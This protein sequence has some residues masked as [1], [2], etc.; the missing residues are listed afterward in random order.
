[1]KRRVCAGSAVLL[2]LI[3]SLCPGMGA[4]AAEEPVS[5][6]QEAADTGKTAQP[7]AYR[8]YIQGCPDMYGSG[9]VT[10]TAEDAA[11]TDGVKRESGYAGYAD[12]AGKPLSALLTAPEA[13]ATWRVSVPADGRYRLTVAYYPMEGTGKSAERTLLLDGQVP[14]A[15]AESLCFERT[16]GDDGEKSVDKNGNES[17]PSQIETPRWSV[18]TLT[19]A[20]GF[21]GEALCLY[22]TAG[23][24]TVSLAGLREPVAF[25]QLT[26]SPAAPVPTYAEVRAAA[27]YPDAAG[28]EAVAVIPAETAGAR[29]DPTLY[30]TWDRSSPLT[31]PMDYHA[32]RLNTIGGTQ[33][34]LA[35]QW[36]EWTFTVPQDGCYRIALRAR[37][38]QTAG[39]GASR[40]L[41][42][43]GE[44]PFAEAAQITVPYSSR[45][46]SV[47]LGDKQGD[48]LFPLSAGTH[49]LRL[50]VT[51]GEL[52]ELAQQTDALLARL[53]RVYREIL[54]ITGTSPDTYRDYYLDKEIPDTLKEMAALSGELT[55]LS[56]ALTEKTGGRSAQNSLLDRLARETAQMSEKPARVAQMLS[57]FK[58]DL[59]SLGSWSLGIR[60]QPLELDTIAVLPD[61]A[62]APAGDAGFFAGL[63]HEL[64]LFAAAFTADYTGDGG[65][66]DENAVE[67]WVTGGREQ[68]QIQRQMTAREYSAKGQGAVNIRL[69]ASSA[70]LPSVL[71]GRCGDVV[72]GVASA[73]VMDLAARGALLPLA[74]RVDETALADSFYES[75]LLPLRYEGTLY[76]L[77]DSQ[78]F[79]VVFY[80]TDIF[81]ELGITVPDTWEELY[82]VLYVL[83]QNR[84]DFGLPATMSSYAAILYQQG[85]A[86]YKDGGRRSCMGDTV[87]I[88]AFRTYADL[89][90]QYSL[91]RTYDLANRFRSGE[92]PLAVAD[93]STTYNQLTVFAPE[94]RGRWSFA[95]MIGTKRA[96]G[97]VDRTAVSSVTGAVILKTAADPD[98]CV[99]FVQW[100]TGADAQARYAREQESVMGAAARYPVA[101]R[102]AMERIDWDAD[103]LAVLQAQWAQVRGIPEVPGGYYTSRYVDF[104]YKAVVLRAKNAREVLADYADV[105]DRELRS[106][107]E[108]FGLDT[109]TDGKE[110]TP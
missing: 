92:M 36:I 107:R 87:N 57:T 26:L 64:R 105:I 96:D 101:N 56:A 31:E 81:E 93:Y 108:E 66:A 77:P 15:E 19:D 12:E 44:L 60:E 50:T 109:A 1:M 61:R 68:A 59:S 35:G 14:F 75:A 95:P 28:T 91:P 104:A 21:I 52:G 7:P 100:W 41:T 85:G 69:V 34:R 89:F 73:T 20:D 71:S 30:A 103:R 49:T 90:V 6:V 29:S 48:W 32:I 76:A 58:S 42:I 11:E 39:V 3:G 65:D 83:A 18:K 45:W 4:A 110:E 46:Q 9:S 2:L 79:P 47:V 16:F 17:R 33:W 62:A 37:K 86:F 27:A 99:R 78:N 51:L 97:T 102:E 23:T 88:N 98:G 70:V 13:T 84:M 55:A 25:G 74:G 22:L 8:D 54:V 40:C 24:H 67:V 10:V 94:I 38:N 72:L 5:S 53:E 80:R 106:K 63:W 82:D 43:D